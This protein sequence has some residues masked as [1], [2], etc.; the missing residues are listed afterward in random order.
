[1]GKNRVVIYLSDGHEILD[2][3]VKERGKKVKELIE[4]ALQYKDQLSEIQADVLEM[5]KILTSGTMPPLIPE[6][7]K[8]MTDADTNLIKDILGIF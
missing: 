8:I 4:F 5:K 3:P 6:E 2:L 7:S 1:M